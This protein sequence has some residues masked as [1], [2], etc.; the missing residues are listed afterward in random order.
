ME[1]PV[2]RGPVMVV[3]GVGKNG[4]GEICEARHLANHDVDV[5]LALTRPNELR[6]VSEQQCRIYTETGTS[7]VDSFLAP[8][9]AESLLHKNVHHQVVIIDA[10][11]GYGSVG[12]VR[13]P[14]ASFINRINTIRKQFRA[15]YR[16]VILLL[17]LPSGMPADGV[18]L[19]GFHSK[20]QYHAINEIEVGNHQCRIKD[21]PVVEAVYPERCTKMVEQQIQAR[22]IENEAVLRAMRRVPRHLFVT[23][24]ERSRAYNEHAVPIGFGLTISQPFIVAYMTD[25]LCP[26]PG[27]RILEIGTGSGYQAAVLVEIIAELD[28]QAADRLASLDYRNVVLADTDGYWGWPDNAPFDGTIVTAEAGH[29]PPPLVAQLAPG[30][31]MVLPMGHPYATQYITLIEKSMN[32]TL[33]G[34]QLLP[35]RFFPFTRHIESVER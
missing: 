24:E 14:E 10:M 20:S 32:G 18:D 2:H 7:L 17:D 3:A 27:D 16:V 6:T 21:T 30:G 33:S 22:G 23:Q 15:G 31:H 13:E 11:R 9:S 5:R 12:E 29:I 19:F 35:V 8:D 25:L 28:V 1:M 4:G 26:E 34:R